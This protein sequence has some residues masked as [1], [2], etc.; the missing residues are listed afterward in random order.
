MQKKANALR[1]K[2]GRNYIAIELLK[3]IEES[4]SKNAVVSGVRNLG[5]LE[6]LKKQKNFHLI[7]VDAPLEMRYKRSIARKDSKDFLSLE[8]F[9]RL[10]QIDKGF[11]QNESGQQN[12]AVMQQAD[13]TIINDKGEKE[14]Q[15]K[16]E[17]VLKNLE[18]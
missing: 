11:G 13:F 4:K 12:A 8:E 5:E 16:V 10:D 15:E 6:E 7:A 17:E 3:R 1:E 18:K 2:F 14:L 9:K